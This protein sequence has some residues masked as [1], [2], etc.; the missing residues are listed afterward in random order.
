[1]AKVT[2]YNEFLLK[3]LRNP[4]EAAAYL[5]A[6]LAEGEPALFLKALGKVAEARGGMTKLAAKTKVS[7]VALYRIFSERGNPELR[8]IDSILR[9]FDLRLSVNHGYRR[10]R[11]TVFHAAD[12]SRPE[13]ARI[14]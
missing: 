6:V 10:R 9:A 4:K 2:D 8:T 5:D 3:H 1:M 13:W 7:R 12:S 11:E 14:R